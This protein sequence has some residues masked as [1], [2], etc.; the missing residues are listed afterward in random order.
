M[1]F[2]VCAY[3]TDDEVYTEHSKNF[4]VSLQNLS[5]AYDIIEM[6]SLTDWYQGMQYKPTFLKEML[7]KHSPHS[8]VY[9]DIDAVF[10]KYPL[11]FDILDRKENIV[12]SAHILDHSKYRRN[13]HKPELLSGTLFLKNCDRTKSLV[14]DW[15]AEC[16]KDPKLWDQRALASVIKKGDLT[17]LPEEYCVIFDYMSSIANPVIKHFQASRITRNRSRKD[18]AQVLVK[19]AKPVKVVKN[20]G[21]VHIG[22]SRS[23]RIG[24]FLG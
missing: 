19:S 3:Y 18:K 16:K 1:S 23:G 7:E 8:I 2:V 6:N 12:L 10:C 22:R 5:V 13:R 17:V 4:I 24:G 11:F 15:I 20:D 14:D 21:T 9:V